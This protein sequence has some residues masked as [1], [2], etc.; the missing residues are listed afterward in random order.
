MCET[1]QF[2]PSCST[3]NASRMSCLWYSWTGGKS[4]RPASKTS[5]R[6]SIQLTKLVLLSAITLPSRAHKRTPGEAGLSRRHHFL[7]G[8]HAHLM[9][10][11]HTSSHQSQFHFLGEC[12]S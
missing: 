9:R 2:S 12:C 1:S 11:Y 5:H 8:P 4:A 6:T 7:I 10:T 3:P